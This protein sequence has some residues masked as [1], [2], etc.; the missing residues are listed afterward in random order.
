MGVV[1][2]DG[3]KN[4]LASDVQILNNNLARFS[5]RPDCECDSGCADCVFALGFVGKCVA[6]IMSQREDSLLRALDNHQSVIPFNNLNVSKEIVGI[7]SEVCGV[8]ERRRWGR[9]RVRVICSERYADR[10]RI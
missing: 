4:A 6:I 9:G 1:I 10:C 7:G 8:R 3:F 5:V 2:A